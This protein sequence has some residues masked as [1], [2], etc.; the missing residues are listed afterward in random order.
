MNFPYVSVLLKNIQ[1][2]YRI[3]GVEIS[4]SQQNIFEECNCLPGVV[5]KHF[6]WF[7]IQCYEYELSGSALPF[8]ALILG[9]F[10]SGIFKSEN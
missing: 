5:G 8:S 2:A 4:A 1:T 9:M 6:F 7:S 10:G 3:C